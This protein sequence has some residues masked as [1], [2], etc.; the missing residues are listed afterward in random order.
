[1]NERLV[2]PKLKSYP[3]VS[4]LIAMKNEERYIAPCLDSFKDQLYPQD[5]FEIVICDGKS[6]DKSREIV[7]EYRAKHHNISLFTNEKE[8]S[9][10]G[11][12]LGLKK[13]KGEIIIMM[14]AHTKVASD[15]IYQNARYL[16]NTE[17]SCVGGKVNNV[18]EDYVSK[19]ISLCLSSP[20]GVGNAHYRYLKKEAYVETINYGA[21]WRND[22]DKVGFFDENLLRNVDWDYNYRLRKWGGKLFYTPRIQSFYFNRGTIG[23]L[24]Q[25]WLHNAY[26]K[27]RVFNKYPKSLLPRHLIPPVFVLSLIV[28]FLLAF[29][30]GPFFYV[31]LAIIL[32]YLVGEIA[33]SL[34]I[35]RRAG[36]KYFPLLLLI[37]PVLHFAYGL[38]FLGG[39]FR[40]GLPLKREVS[41]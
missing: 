29:F 15:F 40:F 3:F 8:I 2:L 10:A 7:K 30:F 9:S 25:Q 22:M 33:V 16:L 5:K 38:G 35:A 20:F 21:Y 27:V 14:G 32:A 1:M 37:F 23:K 31:F 11:W 19:T 13:A 17:A 26:W 12:N 6:T 28:S 34:R 41:R 24:F 4:V 39:L 18:G 36:Y